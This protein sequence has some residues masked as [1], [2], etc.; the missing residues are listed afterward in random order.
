MLKLVADPRNAWKSIIILYYN[1]RVIIRSPS[2]KDLGY[3]PNEPN[4]TNLQRVGER[5]GLLANGL[6]VNKDLK[7]EQTQKNTDRA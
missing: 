7:D 2:P 5:A 1:C 3:E 6:T 4:T